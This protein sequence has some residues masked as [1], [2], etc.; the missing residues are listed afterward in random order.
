MTDFKKDTRT[1]EAIADERL[2]WDK[3]TSE[4]LG[5]DVSKIFQPRVLA[6]S[7]YAACITEQVTPR[8]EFIEEL[9]KQ[10]QFERDEWHKLHD[11]NCETISTDELLTK[12]RERG[13]T[14]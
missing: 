14:L 2:P 4:A 9:V 1:A 10:L 12:A 7:G 13:Y 3:S 6:R 11:G 8:D 5:L